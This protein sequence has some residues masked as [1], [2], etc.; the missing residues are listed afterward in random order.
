[1]THNRKLYAPCGMKKYEL[2]ALVKNFAK[3]DD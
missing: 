3:F 1:M 2:F